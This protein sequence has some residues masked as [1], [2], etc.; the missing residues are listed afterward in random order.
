MIVKRMEG[1]CLCVSMMDCIYVQPSDVSVYLKWD[2]NQSMI[3]KENRRE[4]GCVC[5][6]VCV[7]VFWIMSNVCVI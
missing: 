2:Y 5:V 4:R 6:C 1:V 3:G 7:C